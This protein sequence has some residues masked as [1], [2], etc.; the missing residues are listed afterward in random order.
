MHINSR[1]PDLQKLTEEQE[2][3]HDV[4]TARHLKF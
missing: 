1:Y 2:E 3:E 4:K